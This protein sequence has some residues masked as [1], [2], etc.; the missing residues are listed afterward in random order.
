MRISNTECMNYFP[1]KVHPETSKLQDLD[2]L[3]QIDASETR[4]EGLRVAEV[5]SGR[6]SVGRGLGRRRVRTRPPGKP[7]FPRAEA[8]V[9]PLQPVRVSEVHPESKSRCRD[10][11]GHPPTSDS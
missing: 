8:E 2:P 11:P 9:V 6:R 3:A 4:H 10:L 7:C 1:P 5:P